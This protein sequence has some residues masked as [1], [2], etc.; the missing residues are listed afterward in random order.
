MPD[1][2]DMT[3]RIC[4]RLTVLDHWNRKNGKIYWDCRCSCGVLVSVNGAKLRSG[5]TGSCGCLHR[6]KIT[7]HNYHNS[8]TYTSWQSMKDRCLNPNNVRYK[9]YGMRGITI[10]Q[11]WTGSFANFLADMGEQPSLH[12]TIDRR[13]NDGNYEP[14]NC[15]WI[16]RQQQNR[17]T[18]RSR[19][20]THNG[21]TRTLV[22]WAEHI[23]IS[24]NGLAWR[25][26]T[27]WPLERALKR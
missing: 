12:Y 16:T 11:R 27:G 24:K 6:D 22:E 5:L 10:C 23:G 17:N 26:G 3:D 20:L 9:H 2:I 4:Q 8:P 13:D 15:R 14:S 1:F 21:E 19:Y 7:K 18:S 25:L